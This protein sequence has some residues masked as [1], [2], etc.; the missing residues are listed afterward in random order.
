[1]PPLSLNLGEHTTKT[2]LT[3]ALLRAWVDRVL[4]VYAAAEPKAYRCRWSDLMLPEAFRQSGWVR[5][6][7]TDHSPPESHFHREIAPGFGD[8]LW[9]DDAGPRDPPS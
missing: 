3:S 1:M 6:G 5:V 7:P 4:D 9:L 8:D 2:F